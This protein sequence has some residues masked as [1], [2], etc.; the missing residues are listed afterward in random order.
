M[1]LVRD[2]S[3]G[4]AVYLTE[5]MSFVSVYVSRFSAAQVIDNAISVWNEDTA[6]VLSYRLPQKLFS[7]SLHKADGNLN[8][9]SYTEAITA[10]LQ[11]EVEISNSVALCRSIEEI[12]RHLRAHLQAL[13]VDTEI[14][15]SYIEEILNQVIDSI[16]LLD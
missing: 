1:T 14:I 8:D 3:D 5:S 7:G 6:I 4:F 13:G 9:D 2:L 16:I 12:S 15:E 11:N 10:Q